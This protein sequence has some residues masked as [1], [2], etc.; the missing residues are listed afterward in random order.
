MELVEPPADAAPGER[1]SVEGYPG[2]PDAQLAPKKRV[3]E[4]VQPDLAS[5][6]DRI[7]CYRGTPL[8]TPQGP[9]TVAT[10]AGGSIR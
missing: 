8:A 9:C 1:V 5:N 3:F 6:A 10:I 7:A 2:E 4:G